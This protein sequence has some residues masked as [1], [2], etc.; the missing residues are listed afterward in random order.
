MGNFPVVSEELHEF[1]GGMLC[2]LYEWDG[3]T[4]YVGNERGMKTIVEELWTV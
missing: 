1:S 3:Y 2:C 4:I